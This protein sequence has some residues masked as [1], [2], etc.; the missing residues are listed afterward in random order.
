MWKYEDVEMWK[1][2][3]GMFVPLIYCCI[4]ARLKYDAKMGLKNFH[5]STSSY[6]HILHGRLS[7]RNFTVALFC[8][9]EESRTSYFLSPAVT[10]INA[11]LGGMVPRLSAYITSS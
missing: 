4:N 9:L 3:P 7:Y 2:L 11:V 8:S 1:Y 5:I 10:I 6:F